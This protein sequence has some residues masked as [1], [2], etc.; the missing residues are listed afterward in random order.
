MKVDRVRTGVVISGYLLLAVIATIGTAYSVPPPPQIR[1][2]APTE[3]QIKEQFDHER[4]AAEISRKVERSIAA[5]RSIYRANGCTDRY[6]DITG[7]TAYEYGLSAR[8]LAAMVFVESSCNAKAVSGRSSIGLL[9]VNPRVWRY[10]RSD[11]ESPERNMRIGASILKTYIRRYGLVE[12]LHHY[13]GLGDPSDAYAR[14]IFA[15]G[16]LEWRS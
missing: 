8:L 7:R 4:K 1:A 3:K 15:A 16:R 14:R 12:G 6:S 5:A 11:L 9:Q 13:N 2:V 10:S